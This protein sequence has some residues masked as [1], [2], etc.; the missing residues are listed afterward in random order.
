MD[1]PESSLF[2]RWITAILMF[3]FSLGWLVISYFSS[4]SGTLYYFIT[5][6]VCLLLWIFVD[7]QQPEDLGFRGIHR[8]WGGLFLGLILSSLVMF[9]VVIATVLLGFIHLTPV[10]APAEWETAVMILVIY[11][12]E[13]S[14]RAVVEELVA[15][16]YIQQNLATRLNTRFAVGVAAVMFSITHLPGILLR[17]TPPLLL[18]TNMIINI[19]LGGVM[20][21]TAFEKTRTLWFPVGLH[22][23]WNYIQ[24][25]IF[26][27]GGNGLYT[28]QS[29]AWE[30][31]TGGVIGPEA[32]LFGTIALI[33]LILIVWK[34]PSTWIGSKLITEPGE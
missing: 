15:R 21:G 4:L 12:I 22:Y 28:I 29:I 20:L 14:L 9:C 19:F 34:M 24:Y 7:R 17:L 31:L 1:S 3:I 6:L 11:G 33:I 25:H 26:G 8:W 13:Q 30:I 23:G 16:G 27:F 32:G 2:P 10:F 18:A 5:M